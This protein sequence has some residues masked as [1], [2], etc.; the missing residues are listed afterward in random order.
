MAVR[1]ERSKSMDLKNTGVYELFQAIDINGDG[2]LTQ[3]EFVTGLLNIPYIDIS[4][5]EATRMFVNIDTAGT[6]K[7]SPRDF[8]KV[9]ML[10]C[11]K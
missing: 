7:V 11:G 9:I 8:F 2:S 1:R 3:E 4:E 5:T 10:D 6:G